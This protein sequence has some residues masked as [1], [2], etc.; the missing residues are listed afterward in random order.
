MAGRFVLLLFGVLAT[1]VLMTRSTPDIIFEEVDPL[2]WVETDIQVDLGVKRIYLDL[3][4]ISPCRELS[5][6]ETIMDQK[7][8]SA[9]EERCNEVYEKYLM[10]S[11]KKL[12]TCVPKQRRRV[13]RFIP[14]LLG[15]GSLIFS[16]AS[17]I[18]SV[19]Y[20]Y[21]SSGS[22]YNRLNEKDILDNRQDEDIKML[23]VL[24]NQTISA[25]TEAKEL[26]GEMLQ[27]IKSN[28]VLIEENTFL[29]TRLSFLTP[30]I[31]WDSVILF[32][33]IKSDTLRL[34]DLVTS[35]KVNRVNTPALSKLT[36]TSILEDIQEEDT[37]L[38]DVYHPEDSPNIIRLIFTVKVPAVEAK[39]LK[40]QWFHH[41]ENLTTNQPL[42]RYTGPI[43]AIRNNTNNCT[44]SIKPPTTTRVRELCKEE[45]FYDTELDKWEVV[46]KKEEKQFAETQIVSTN[47][48]NIIYCAFKKIFVA[49]KLRQCPPFTF[50][51]PL[52]EPFQLGNHTHSF[53][54]LRLN[55]KS[56]V[57]QLKSSR[58]E[59]KSSKDYEREMESLNEIRIR[60]EKSIQI[61]PLLYENGHFVISELVLASIIVLFILLLFGLGWYFCTQKSAADSISRAAGR[62]NHELTQIIFNNSNPPADQ[63]AQDARDAL[64]FLEGRTLSTRDYDLPNQRNRSRY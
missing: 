55:L 53:E 36:K 28:R 8:Y 42:M 13:K 58:Y 1:T 27:R 19:S 47:Q 3:T 60:N 48:N 62:T 12:A 23:K 6:N 22:S 63:A 57:I 33:L 61:A 14:L 10:N 11:F 26:R 29:I 9:A 2:L 25:L 18:T 38:E 4:M 43:F 46:P 41:H 64:Y 56:Q 5:K 52:D 40:A 17:S 32:D 50:K 24:T 45:S 21:G 31:A 59:G 7:T 39:V 35:C 54:E 49:G 15:A 30:N 16:V 51:L 44:S 20:S 37:F 34:E